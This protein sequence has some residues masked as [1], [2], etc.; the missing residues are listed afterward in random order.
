MKP[1]LSLS[2]SSKLEEI[3]NIIKS[4]LIARCNEKTTLHQLSLWYKE[5]IGEEIPYQD[6]NYAS[7]K[8]FL[9]S[10][11]D[12]VNFYHD[13]KNKLC[14]CHVESDKTKHLSSLIARQV[15]RKQSRKLAS[16]PKLHFSYIDPLLLRKVFLKLSTSSNIKGRF[17]KV[18]A[19]SEI[20]AIMTADDCAHFFYTIQDLNNQLSGWIHILTHDDEYIQLKNPNGFSLEELVKKSTKDRLQKLIEKHEEGIWCTL[21]PDVYRKEYGLDLEYNHLGFISIDEFIMVLPDIFK[22]IKPSKNC[23]YKVVNAKRPLDD[24]YL[25][26]NLVVENVNEKSP[27]I[28]DALPRKS[29]SLLHFVLVSAVD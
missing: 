3:K 12:T 19:L 7:L 6:F 20:K 22:V 27:V 16:K 2:N 8:Q 15:P 11:P 18:N 25:G 4:L 5:E 1:L 29:V 21:L 14:V 24:R 26:S 17:K 13:E 28:K 9:T 23:Q 10:I